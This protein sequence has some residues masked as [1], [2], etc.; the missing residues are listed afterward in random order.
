MIEELKPYETYQAVDSRWILRAPGHWAVKKLRA[1]TKPRSERNRP[2][3]PLLSVARER[4]VFVRTAD[5]DNHNFVPDDLSNYKVARAGSL[6]INK[7]K[8]W[9][10]SMG[11]A[12]TDGIVSPAY[13]VY[14]LSVANRSFGQ[15]LLR[16][17]PYVAHFGQASDGVRVGQWDLSINRMREIPVLLPPA[18]EQEA[19]VR[20]L[21]HANRRID[22]FIRTKKKL[23]ALLNE[24]KRAIIHRAVTRGL[25]PSVRLKDS[26]VPWLGEIPAHWEVRRFRYLL[27]ERLAYGANA[28]AEFDNPSWPRFIRITDFRSDGTLK[29]DTFRSLPPSIAADY[30]VQSGDILLARSGATVGK[31]FLVSGLE[32]DACHA[33][34]LIRAR[35]KTNL[36]LP[37]FAFAFT[38]TPAFGQ[39][40]DVTLNTTTIQNIA[41]DKYADLPVPV[42]PIPEQVAL[43]AAAEGEV[44][45]IRIA[46]LRVER[47]IALI[48]DYRARLVAD[49]VTGQLDVRAAAAGLP[50]VEPEAAPTDSEGDETDTEGGEA[51]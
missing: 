19:I 10:G 36:I 45:P 41:A 43:L 1:L 42:P 7:M 9:Q 2:D 39:W 17:R 50:V 51:A 30:L 8:A 24:Q 27:R 37:E 15:A 13:F 33:G 22:Q 46:E 31:A 29:P 4:G 5:D 21:D 40:K 32:S 49:V 44:A 23:I 11:I 3:L 47:E 14:D 35:V 25:D 26:G 20:F 34:Y 38:Q 28:A 6:V 12:P 16:S 48:R 18:E